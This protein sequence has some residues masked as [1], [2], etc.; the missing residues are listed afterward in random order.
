LSGW[1]LPSLQ[2]FYDA[3]VIAQADLQ[4]EMS[5]IEC[6]DAHCGDT[7]EIAERQFREHLK[8]LKYYYACQLQLSLPDGPSKPV[9]SPILCEFPSESLAPITLESIQK[10]RDDADDDTIL[11]LAFSHIPS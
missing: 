4:N 3:L 10:V 1:T 5:L 6:T 9:Q 8:D 7:I 11:L 2:A